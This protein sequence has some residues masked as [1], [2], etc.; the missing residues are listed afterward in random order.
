LRQRGG[1]I[2]KKLLVLKEGHHIDTLMYVKAIKREAEKRNVEVDVIDIEGI[3]FIR[4]DL[5]IING[6]VESDGI[7]IANP[8][9]NQYQKELNNVMIAWKEKDID[10]YTGVS[11]YPNC[12]LQ[13]IIDVL[14]EKRIN[15]YCGLGKA[16]GKGNRGLHGKARRYS[17]SVPFK[18]KTFKA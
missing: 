18:N 9:S 12:T 5:D 1:I 8:I 4:K 17:Y 10:N 11:L 16:F 3:K 6:L 7:I 2:L 15:R 13:A 14:K